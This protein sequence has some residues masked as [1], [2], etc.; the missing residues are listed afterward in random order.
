MS[1]KTLTPAKRERLCG[2]TLLCDRLGITADRLPFEAS[3]AGLS[4]RSDELLSFWNGRDNPT[5]LPAAIVAAEIPG[6]LPPNFP[7]WDVSEPSGLTAA[8]HAAAAGNVEGWNRFLW[9][10]AEETNGRTAAHEYVMHNTPSSD[11]PTE[12]WGLRDNDG[13]TVAHTAAIAGTLPE[14]L[15]TDPSVMRLTDDNGVFVAQFVAEF[16]EPG[17]DWPF[18]DLHWHDPEPDPDFPEDE[19]PKTLRE[20]FMSPSPSL[21]DQKPQTRRQGAEPEAWVE[22][23][24]LRMEFFRSEGRENPARQWGLLSDIYT[25]DESRA[26]FAGKPHFS[27]TSEQLRE[28]LEVRSQDLFLPIV[29]EDSP[30]ESGFSSHPVLSLGRAENDRD[31][32][33]VGWLHIPADRISGIPAERVLDMAHA[34]LECV[35]YFVRGQ[36]WD[37]VLRRGAE[38]LGRIEQFYGNFD[39]RL[40]SEMIGAISKEIGQT[41][42]GLEAFEDVRSVF[43]LQFEGRD[44][45]VGERT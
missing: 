2:L 5:R 17:P 40:V 16:S 35:D 42:P 32:M 36:V 28:E 23:G 37:A 31:P 25:L 10:I 3:E 24:G 43:D 19:E 14:A 33:I 34:D 4:A 8:H 18:W 12:L 21:D 39:S 44:Q 20:A 30:P 41:V 26:G 13:T 22:Q 7:Y 29:K 11:F 6:L 27:R 38:E 15:K 1:E 9:M 45:T